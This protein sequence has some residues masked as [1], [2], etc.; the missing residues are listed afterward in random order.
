M[1]PYLLTYPDAKYDEGYRRYQNG[2]TQRQVAESLGIPR[3]SL[4]RLSKQDGWEEERRARRIEAETAIL[5]PAAP[6]P[7]EVGANWAADVA[8]EPVPSSGSS[9]QPIDPS[10]QT[11][12][13]KPQIPE[14]EP[15]EEPLDGRPGI[16]RML[17]RQQRVVDRLARA[18]DRAS[19]ELL[20]GLRGKPARTVLSQV[21][22]LVAL[23][24]RLFEMQRKAYRVP[25]KMEVE[26][27]T[28]TAADRVRKLTDDQLNDQLSAARAAALEAERRGRVASDPGE[29]PAQ[30]VN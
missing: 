1:I 26:D 4:A 3:R 20:A 13:P 17:R 8:P 7:S 25:D 15:D 27:T 24:Q 30:S 16:D 29:A 18:V 22:S 5:A 19:A 10:A 28:P 11:A 2:E 23:G 21:T 9:T 6:E 14:P 12:V